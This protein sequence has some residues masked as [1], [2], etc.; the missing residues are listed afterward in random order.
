MG[1]ENVAVGVSRGEIVVCA[2]GMTAG[3]TADVVPWWVHKI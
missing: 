1:Y 3:R 2:W